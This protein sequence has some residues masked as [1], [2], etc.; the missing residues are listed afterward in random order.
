MADEQD[1]VVLKYTPVNDGDYILGVP[2]RDLTERDM[3]RIE[4]VHLHQMTVPG[5]SGKALYT[6]ANKNLAKSQERAGK[7]SAEAAATEAGTGD[8]A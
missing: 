5:A 3:R 4:P 1:E 8:K 2:A 7:E 6:Y